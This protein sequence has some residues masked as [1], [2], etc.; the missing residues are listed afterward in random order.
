MLYKE[1]DLEFLTEENLPEKVSHVSANPNL[2]RETFDNYL[3]RG[4]IDVV[5]PSKP[6]RG[7]G[8]RVPIYK[9]HRAHN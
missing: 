4:M 9:F 8:R 1:M 7:F 5:N 6:L 2:I 3:R